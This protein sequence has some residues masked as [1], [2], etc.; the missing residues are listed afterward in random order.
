MGSGKGKA[1]KQ[2]L[3]VRNLDFNNLKQTNVSCQADGVGNGSDEKTIWNK[4]K[5]PKQ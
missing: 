2:K 3:H 5:K 4:Q 1:Q